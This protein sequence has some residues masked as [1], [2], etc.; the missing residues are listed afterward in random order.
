MNNIPQTKIGVV[1]VSRD[2]FPESLSRRRMES[3]KA[4]CQG[5]LGENDVYFCPTIIVESEIDM[6]TAYSQCLKAGCNALCVYLGNFGPEI[7]ETML[8]KHWTEF[9]SGPVMVM[10]AAEEEDNDLIDQRGDAFCGLLNASYNLNLRGVKAYIPANP[11]VLPEDGAR[12]LSY[13]SR[14]AKVIYGL[15]HLK[16]ISFGPRPTNFLACNAPIKGFFD[17]GVEVEENSELDLYKSFKAHADDGRIAAVEEEMKKELGEGHYIEKVL[18][19]LAQYELT[20]LD[21]IKE[22]KGEREFVALS[23]KCWPAFQTEFGF[24]PC[25]VNSRLAAQGYPVSCEVDLYGALSEWIGMVLSSDTP[26]LL[27][28]NNTVP[29]RI[30]EADIKGKFDYRPSDLFMGFH[31]GNTCS[32]K[33]CHPHMANQRIMARTL[34]EDV[35]NGTIEGDILPG[36]VTIFRLQGHADGSLGSYVAEGEVLPV[37]TRSFGSIGI[38]AVKEMGRFYRYE[39]LANHFPHHAAVAFA[40]IGRELYDVFSYLGIKSIG[41]NHSINEPYPEENPFAK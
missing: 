23:T 20:L 14:L 5:R 13:F 6:M 9:P 19:R 32:A 1:G 38:F 36:D 33:L 26:T 22:H 7:A 29:A 28:I 15:E 16:L 35:T 41:Y 17:L 21:W 37:P 12:E 25:Y 4:A 3:L 34:P 39:L 8:A 27:D 30:F 40:H 10:A 11:V 31:C 2:C 18:P 24:V